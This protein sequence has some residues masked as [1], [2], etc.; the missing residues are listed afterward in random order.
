MVK[1]KQKIVFLLPNLE[2]PDWMVTAI[3]TVAKSDHSEIVALFHPSITIKNPLFPPTTT[4][5]HRLYRRYLKSDMKK[6]QL[7]PDAFKTRNLQKS[8][9]FPI[10]EFTANR[11]DGKLCFGAD[12]EGSAILSVSS[13]LISLIDEELGFKT[14]QRINCALWGIDQALG[15]SKRKGPVGVWEFLNRNEATGVGIVARKNM[16]SNKQV[17]SES[18]SSTDKFGLHRNLNNVLWKLPF[19]LERALKKL[20]KIGPD[21]FYAMAAKHYPVPI[22]FL[23]KKYYPGNLEVVVGLALNYLARF[24]IKIDR[25]FNFEQY[26]L[27]FKM[28]RENTTTQKFDEFKRILPPKDRFWADPF[29]LEKDN[30]HYIFIEELI[31]K[32]KLGTIGVIKMD[33]NGVFGEPQMV[34]EKDYHLSYP[35]LIE[36]DNELYMIP[37]SSANSTIQLYKCVDFPLKWKLEEIIMN[38]VQALDTTVYWHNNRYWMF[39]NMKEHPGISGYDELF[40]FHSA[41]L[42]GGNWIPHPEN[43]IVSDVRSARPAGGIFTKNGKLYRPAQNCAKRYGYGMQLLEIKKLTTTEYQEEIVQS[44]YPDWANDLRTTHTINH[45]GKLTVIDALI[46]RRK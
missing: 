11:K 13:V 21:A 15:H 17:L 19:M 18:F 30:A 24:R 34:I 44:I 14:Q 45:N 31:Y 26:I 3:H 1:E 46:G 7:T 28:G 6:Y 22:T 2:I 41:S 10:I 38:D 40:L 32:N 36:E 25:N 9:D 23:Q 39:S 8:F 4:F 35:F 29:V 5:K 20:H 37:E 42:V 43:P 16:E 33:E 27:L 12:S